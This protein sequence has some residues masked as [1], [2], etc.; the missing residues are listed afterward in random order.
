MVTAV[1]HIDYIEPVEM[2]DT[3]LERDGNKTGNVIYSLSA[4][5]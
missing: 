3:P 1:M 5:I 2:M 4:G